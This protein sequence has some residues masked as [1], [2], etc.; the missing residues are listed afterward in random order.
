MTIIAFVTD[1]DSLQRLLE[2]LGESTQPP[3]IAPA[4]GPPHGEEDFDQRSWYDPT[5]GDPSPAY[6]FAQT[7]SW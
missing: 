6:E 2:H 4:R 7:V 1:G 3:P 5:L